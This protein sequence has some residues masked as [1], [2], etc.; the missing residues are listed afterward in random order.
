MALNRDRLIR[1]W[2]DESAAAREARESEIEAVAEKY[3][4]ELEKLEEKARK[5]AMKLEAQRDQVEGRQLNIDALLRVSPEL[6]S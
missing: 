3:N 4:K 2:S 5:Q 1:A 6:V